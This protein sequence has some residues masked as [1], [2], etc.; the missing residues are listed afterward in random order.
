MKSL[1]IIFT[2]MLSM[3]A[4]FLPT[5][6]GSWQSS[7]NR[8]FGDR[9]WFTSSVVNGKIYVIGGYGDSTLAT[10]LDVFNPAT[11]SWS[12]L[13]TTGTFTKRASLA[14]C[15]MNDK[16][17]VFGGATGPERPSNMSNAL[18]IFDPRTNKWTT[19]K[20]RGTF[21]PRNN[22]CACPINGK[23]YTLG[24]YNAHSPG[25]LNI[26]EVFDPKTNT[27]S[28]P[29]TSGNF[30]PHGAFTANVV[31]GK[32]Y[33][34][35]GFNDQGQRGHR[36]IGDVEVFDPKTNTWSTPKA[37]GT[38]TARLLHASGV[39]GNKIYIIGGTPN[40][41]DP[42]TKDIVQVFDPATNSWST[43]ENTGTFTPRSYLSA[44][45]VNNKIYAIGGQ[46]TSQVFNTV[47]IY[48]P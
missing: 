14:S 31:N 12:T 37:S 17:Y 4:S 39:L 48:T 45:V 43:P 19:P 16:I 47:E 41:V 32:I 38:F 22:L 20:T 13:T 10:T 6:N 40:M 28:T 35:G 44:S 46:D 36:V 29:K 15:V 33:A 24:G 42:L 3:G 9:A 21:T 8:G 26:M 11:D 34:I 18:E 25:D 30:T 7:S 23:I 2:I 5:P 1:A 27:W